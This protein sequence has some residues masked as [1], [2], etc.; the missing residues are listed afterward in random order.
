[1]CWISDE[2]KCL[3][4]GEEKIPVFKIVM[5]DT[6]RNTLEAYYRGTPYILNKEYHAIVVPEKC[7]PHNRYMISKGL[8]CYDNTCNFRRRF[9]GIC[10]IRSVYTDMYS[11]AFYSDYNYVSDSDCYVA[12]VVKGYIPPNTYYYVNNQNEIVTTKLVLTDVLD[13]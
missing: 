1:M 7:W 12:V 13:L 4:S 11:T 2:A 10:V 6:I 8:H 5:R 9:D 3:N